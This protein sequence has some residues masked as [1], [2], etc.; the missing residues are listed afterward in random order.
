MCRLGA[1]PLR[2][3]DDLA[4]RVRA[5]TGGRGADVVLDSVGRATHAASLAAVAAFGR[6]S[7]SAT[8]AAPCRRSMS[9]RCSPLDARRRLQSS[10]RRRPGA[11]GRGQAPS[12]M[13][14]RPERSRST[15]RAPCPSP[16]RPSPPRARIAG[17]SSGKI[18]LLPLTSRSGATSLPSAAPVG[19]EGSSSAARTGILVLRSERESRCCLVLP[20]AD[21]RGSPRRYPPLGY[22]PVAAG[23]ASL[24]SRRWPSGSRKKQRTSQ[25]WS[26]GG[27]RN[28]APRPRSVS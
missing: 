15:S 14:S 16:R 9:R 17:A 18:V 2:Y 3:G 24:S 27:V 10:P 4:E 8:R 5:A 26:T 23:L 19:L 1:E 25:P 22:S 11:M 13:W 21:A 6:S 7:S 20:V 12:S 28:S